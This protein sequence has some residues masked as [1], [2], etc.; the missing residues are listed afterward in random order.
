MTK[1]VA[2][3][4]PYGFQRGQIAPKALTELASLP[5]WL[6]LSPPTPQQDSVSCVFVPRPPSTMSL[7]QCELATF[8]E[9]VIKE[10]NAASASPND[11]ESLIEEDAFA[12]SAKIARAHLYPYRY[13]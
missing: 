10:V 1:C 2:L 4:R 9:Y 6:S 7:Q 5:Q 12:V 8:H 13:V 11:P 3:Q